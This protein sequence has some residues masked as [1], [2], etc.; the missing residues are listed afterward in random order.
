MNSMVPWH[1]QGLIRGL[2]LLSEEERHN[3]HIR[4]SGSDL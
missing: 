3:R 1:L 4:S 2:S